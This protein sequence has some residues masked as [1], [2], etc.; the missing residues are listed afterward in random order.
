LQAS[1][2]TTN[3][4]TSLLLSFRRLL[5]AHELEYRLESSADFQT[6]SLVVGEQSEPLLNADGTIT[7]SMNAGSPA[8]SSM[9]FFRLRISMK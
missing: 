7:V 3:G 6:W 2:S 1:V 5:L 8:A 4:S 9:R